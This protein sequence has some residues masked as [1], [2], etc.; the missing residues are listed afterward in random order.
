MMSI[1]AAATFR[2]TPAPVFAF[3]LMA[4]ALIQVPAQEQYEA[5]HILI[6][7]EGSGRSAAPRTREE[8]ETLAKELLEQLRTNPS[9]FA[10]LA[11]QHS[12]CPSSSDGGYLGKFGP[13]A[14]VAPFE[15]AVANAHPG[16]IVGP[17]ETQFGF[18][19]IQRL[20][21]DKIPVGVITVAFGD[22]A[23]SI[24]LTRTLEEAR[25]RAQEARQA[26]LDGRSFSEVA[27][28]YSD[29]PNAAIGGYAGRIGIGDNFPPAAL[30]AALTLEA[31]AIS[32][33][34]EN[35][36]VL[37]VVTRLSDADADAV[38]AML[39]EA[40]ELRAV[41]LRYA[42]ARNASSEVT[43]SREEALELARDISSRVTAGEPLR[44]FAIQFATTE[45]ERNRAGQLGRLTRRVL[46]P[47][48]AEAAFRLRTNQSTVV[49]LPEGFVVIQRVDDG[50]ATVPASAEPVASPA[51]PAAEAPVVEAPAE[52]AL[53]AIETAETAAAEAP[54]AEEAPVTEE[55]SAAE[56]AAAEAP[57][58]EEAPVADETPAAEAPAE[59]AGAEATEE[60][61]AVEEVA[62]ESADAEAPATEEGEAA[63]AETPA[64]EDVAS[65]APAEEVA[66]E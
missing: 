18:H 48:V 13:G 10:A 21:G 60:T 53:E 57:A 12:N 17:V 64:T 44:D 20:G 32:E 28:A 52:A 56:E 61:P 51:A 30:D 26:V 4:L 47:N 24:G 6:S 14:M 50:P 58:V 62:T 7:H 40:V 35:P 31:G 11:L 23:E 34:V 1:P 2:R 54:A 55:A 49:E 8:A 19:I 65:E 45:A 43:R 66:A 15:Q 41:F 16:E 3:L 37:F 33:V 36:M 22:A 27:R 29:S 42:G 39:N 63:P 59:E 9:Q 5:R 25:A 46:P 38:E